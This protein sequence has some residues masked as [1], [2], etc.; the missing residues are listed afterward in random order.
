MSK[1]NLH[2][3]LDRAIE[4]IASMP[5][6]KIVSSLEACA[7]GPISYALDYAF[8]EYGKL[9]SFSIPGNFVRSAAYDELIGSY[10]GMSDEVTLS[11][12]EYADKFIPDSSNDDSYLLAA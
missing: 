5:S 2:Q 11:V 4:E 10:M 1:L 9:E 8:S 7:G 12:C 3:A 6:D